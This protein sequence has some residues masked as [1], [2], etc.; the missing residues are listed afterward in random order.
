MHITFGQHPLKTR[1]LFIEQ[2][3]R[4]I[5]YAVEC[6]PA[7]FTNNII[8]QIRKVKYHDL[9]NEHTELMVQYAEHLKLVKLLVANEIEFEIIKDKIHLI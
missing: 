7:K 1:I 2:Q 4:W 9:Y 8:Q 6:S 3:M 5:K